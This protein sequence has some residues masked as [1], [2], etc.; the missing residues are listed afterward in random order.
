M[1]RPSQSTGL[2][3][4][5]S[6]PQMLSSDELAGVQGGVDTPPRQSASPSRRSNSPSSSR[7]S[8]SIGSSRGSTPRETASATRRRLE[9]FGPPSSRDHSAAGSRAPAPS[10]SRSGTRRVAYSP[11]LLGRHSPHRSSGSDQAEASKS[12][13]TSTRIAREFKIREAARSGDTRAKAML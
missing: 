3:G 2:L 4:E 1:K 6:L 10:R 8:P 13:S 9:L 5:P 12:K 11:H 7:T